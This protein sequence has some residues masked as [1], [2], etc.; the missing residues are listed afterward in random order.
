M[1][2]GATTIWSC[3]KKYYNN[4]FPLTYEFGRASHDQNML[5]HLFINVDFQDPMEKCTTR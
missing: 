4:G 2:H 1:H 5:C 3:K